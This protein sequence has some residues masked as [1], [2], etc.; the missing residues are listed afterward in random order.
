MNMMLIFLIVQ[1]TIIVKLKETFF[2]KNK[3]INISIIQGG[4]YN[5]RNRKTKSI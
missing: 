4:N 5:E 3:L 1:S 2:T